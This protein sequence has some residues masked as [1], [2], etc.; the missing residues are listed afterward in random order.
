M[1][2]VNANPGRR[3]ALAAAIAGEL[4]RQA[5]HGTTRVDV[6]ALTEAVE[7]VLSAA[8]LFAEGKR[9]EQLNA[10]NDD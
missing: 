5:E 2:T 10:T 1:E 3:A 4:R 8:P 6:E 9:P 7:A